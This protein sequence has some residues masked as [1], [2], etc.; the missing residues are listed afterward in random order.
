MALIIL[1]LS[2]SCCHVGVGIAKFVFLIKYTVDV[3]EV[4]LECD[5][6]KYSAMDKWLI[7]AWV[8]WGTASCYS[9]I[10]VV[11]Q[12]LQNDS[13]DNELCM[14]TPWNRWKE[15]QNVIH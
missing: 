3:G 1:V 12:V 11:A 10:A 14:A 4:D 9:T 15:L 7:M 13:S 8:E 6:D 5:A 2:L